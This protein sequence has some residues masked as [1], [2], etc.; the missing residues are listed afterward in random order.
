MLCLVVGERV[1]FSVEYV[2]LQPLRPPFESTES[3]SPIESFRQTD[4]GEVSFYWSSLYW[5][6]DVLKF[7]ALLDHTL[8]SVVRFFTI[9]TMKAVTSEFLFFIKEL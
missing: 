1:I 2:L 7:P 6:Y 5:F 4:I 9:G 8:F 3:V